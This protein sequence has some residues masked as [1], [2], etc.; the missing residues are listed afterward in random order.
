[1]GT[2]FINLM[3]VPYTLTL[4]YG[5]AKPGFYRAVIAFLVLLPLTLI[6]SL[7][8]AGVGAAFAWAMFNL[9]SLILFPLF[10]HRKLLKTELKHWVIADVGFPAITAAI[11]LVIVYWMIPETL[12]VI[13]VI[14]AVVFVLLFTFGC[15]VLSARDIRGLALEYLGKMTPRAF[16]KSHSNNETVG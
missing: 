6:L 14:V 1:M 9:G 13:Q 10:V 7:R 3:G 8:Y 4:A 15:T 2:I 12:S 11:I 16:K 5:W